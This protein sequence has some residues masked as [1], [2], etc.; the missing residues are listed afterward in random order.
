MSKGGLSFSLL[1]QEKIMIKFY[2]MDINAIAERDFKSIEHKL[3][4]INDRFNQSI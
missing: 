2:E 3:H 4:W 1:I